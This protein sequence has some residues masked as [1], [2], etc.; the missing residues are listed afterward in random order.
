MGMVQ[1][2]EH[3]HRRQSMRGRAW[4]REAEQHQRNAGASRAP[5]NCCCRGIFSRRGAVLRATRALL[6]NVTPQPPRI[7]FLQYICDF[8]L[9]IQ[10]VWIA[11]QL[12]KNNFWGFYS[13]EKLTH[14]L[15]THPGWLAGLTAQ[16]N[17]GQFYPQPLVTHHPSYV[18]A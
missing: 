10:F 5:G 15:P 2:A 18:T 8:L 12:K 16:G 11:I 13:I 17:L 3:G 7:D 6:T 14:F 1:E 4:V 9:L